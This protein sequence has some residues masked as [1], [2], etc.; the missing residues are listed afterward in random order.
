MQ[1]SRPHPAKSHRLPP[2]HQ[3]WQPP[4]MPQGVRELWKRDCL[5]PPG[6]K[7]YTNNVERAKKRYRKR[8][9]AFISPKCVALFHLGQLQCHLNFSKLGLPIVCLW[10]QMKRCCTRVR[11]LDVEVTPLAASLSSP[12]F[13]PSS[14]EPSSLAA[15]I[16]ACK[17]DRTLCALSQ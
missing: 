14:P 8:R 1:N 17:N 12:P 6:T 2:C 10:K 15:L 4:D 16:A 9:V 13:A 7:K 11:T 5:R 3:L